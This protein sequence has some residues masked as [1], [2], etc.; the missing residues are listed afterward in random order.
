MS[1]KVARITQEKENAEAKY[2]LKRKA[3]KDIESN[4]GK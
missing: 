4:L 3:L 2:D 1:E